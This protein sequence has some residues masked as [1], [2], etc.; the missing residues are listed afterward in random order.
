MAAVEEN[1][2]GAGLRTGAGTG[3]AELDR[4]FANVRAAMAE[5]ALDGLVVAGSEYSGFEGAVTYLSGFQIVHRYA[6]VVVPPE[7]DPFVVFPAEARYVGEHGTALIEQRFDPHPG[8]AI[9]AYARDARWRR[10]GVYGLDYV[11]TVRDYRP[12]EGF[13][14][15]PFDVEFDL[16]RAVK[17][18]AELVSVRDSVRINRRG[19]EIWADAYAPGRTAAEVMAVAEEYFIA[20][21]CGRLTMNMVLTAPGRS[22]VA[23]PE[24]KIARKE[25]VLGDFV[26]PSLEVAGP[27]MHWVEVSRA[28]A[29]QGTP[30]SEDTKAM[31][32][33]YDEYFEAA[34][35][36]MRAGASCHDVHVAVSK[37]FSDRGYHL[38]HVTGHSIGMTMIE[39]PKVGEGV[40]TELRE[41]MVLSMHPHA[42][43]ANGEDCL[44][45]QDT[46]LVTAEG[47]VPLAG[48]PMEIVVRGD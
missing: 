29:A 45:M 7:R 28:V 32:E 31:A 26:L 15:V 40:E 8:A 14:I 5:H 38:G 30:L 13:E 39:F 18:E 46:W 6:Y 27:G 36:A 2:A 48:L 41:N 43:A 11:M 1:S 9:V 17:S 4:R 23:L 21:G 20:E 47:G 10:I 35:T 16:A 22:G 42:I 25:E 12:L 33:A 37:G 3:S 44:Y 24:F 34:K 19:F